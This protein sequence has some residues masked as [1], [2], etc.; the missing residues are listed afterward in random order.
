MTCDLYRL[1]IHPVCKHSHTLR[2]WGSGLWGHRSAQSSL[3]RTRLTVASATLSGFAPKQSSTHARSAW[4]RTDPR[5]QAHAWGRG[6]AGPKAAVRCPCPGGSSPSQRGRRRGEGALLLEGTEGGTKDTW[7]RAGGG[8]PLVH[9]PWGSTLRG[10]GPVKGHGCAAARSHR[11]TSDTVRVANTTVGKPAPAWRARQPRPQR[12][13]W[14][15]IPVRRPPAPDALPSHRGPLACFSS[16]LGRLRGGV[17]APW[18]PGWA[19]G[20]HA[21]FG[22]P[23]LSDRVG[24][25]DSAVRAACS[26]RLASGSRRPHP[27][28]ERGSV[29]G[30]PARQRAGGAASAGR[31]SPCPGLSKCGDASDPTPTRRSR[32]R[33]ADP[34]D[35][36]GEPLWPP[37]WGAPGKP[38]PATLGSPAGAS[39]CAPRPG[40]VPPPRLGHRPVTCREQDFG[41]S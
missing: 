18:G 11:L 25:G 24:G 14:P 34:R 10:S 17:G 39:L 19:S 30:R 29:P 20:Q 27:Q 12:P 2:R 37:P 3:S 7:V 22:A 8:C 9:T 13:V 33:Y 40:R 16:V 28:V 6:Q 35:I 1:R 36:L 31:P 23:G 38:A 26:D 15:P 41:L 21:D 5:G 4:A 32:G